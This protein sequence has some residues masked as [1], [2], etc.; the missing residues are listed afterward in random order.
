[1]QFP[2]TVSHHNNARCPPLLGEKV[3]LLSFV[4]RTCDDINGCPLSTMVLYSVANRLAETP[5]LA[6]EL[7]LLTISFDPEGDT[8]DAMA[9]YEE[10]IL[11]DAELDWHFL[12]SASSAQIQPVLD[13]YQQS[14]VQDPKS[15]DGKGKFSHILRV[16]LIDQEQQIRNIYNLSFLHPDILVNDIQTI[17]MENSD[18]GIARQ[19]Q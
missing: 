17:L 9:E 18:K 2:E 14:V 3:S 12:T 11:G 1:M 5:E 6:K 13:A 15:E 7:R 19:Q 16:Y 8:P 10:S 4:Y